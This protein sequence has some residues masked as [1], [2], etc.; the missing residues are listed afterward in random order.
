MKNEMIRN[1]NELAIEIEELESK[2]APQ[3]D[4]TFLEI[5]PAPQG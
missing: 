1:G 2:L 3:A 4:A 5:A